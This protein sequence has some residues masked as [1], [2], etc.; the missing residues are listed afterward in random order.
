MKKHPD[1]NYAPDDPM[2]SGAWGEQKTIESGKTDTIVISLNSLT[3]AAEFHGQ[4]LGLT[5]TVN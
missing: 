3:Y 1:S 2:S 4:D 5:L